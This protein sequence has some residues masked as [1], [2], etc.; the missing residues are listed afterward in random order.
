VGEAEDLE[1]QALKV[2]VPAA[3]AL[4]CVARAVVAEA[5]GLGDQATVAP[6][7]VD[8]VR[9]HARVCLGLGKAVTAAQGEEHPLE[10]GAGEVVGPLEVAV[11]DQAQIQ[12]TPDGGPEHRQ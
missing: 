12:G 3:V 6:E 11:P 9:A 10:L 1:A 8:L 2:G 5:V 7:E 4:E